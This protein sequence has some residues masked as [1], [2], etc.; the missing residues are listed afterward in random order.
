MVAGMGT[1]LGV[2]SGLDA[3]VGLQT[4][5]RK[6]RRNQPPKTTL[7]EGV[8][9]GIGFEKGAWQGY[10]YPSLVH[11]D[12]PDSDPGSSHPWPQQFD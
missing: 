2:G 9:W 5:A 1:S 11:L 4:A 6:N 3:L 12:F 10:P 7:G 8:Q